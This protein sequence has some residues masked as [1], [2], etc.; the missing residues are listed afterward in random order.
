MQGIEIVLLFGFKIEGFHGP[1]MNSRTQGMITQTTQG[2]RCPD[3]RT[4]TRYENMTRQ[5]R[6]TGQEM[7]ITTG[8]MGKHVHS[9]HT[10]E[11]VALTG[12]SR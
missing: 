10:E 9:V 11:S 7:V 1:E 2:I 12:P 3:R 5:Y 4:A 6:K 8:W